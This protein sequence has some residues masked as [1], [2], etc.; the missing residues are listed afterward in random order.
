MNLTVI[1]II[2]VLLTFIYFFRHITTSS[3]SRGAA[4]ERRLEFILESLDAMGFEGHCLNNVFVPRKN[5][6]TTEIDVLF[7]TRK[8]LFVIESK[9]I[10]GY[11]FGHENRRN[12][13]STLYAGRRWYGN[14]VNKYHFFNPIWQNKSHINALKNYCGDITAFS[15]I[16]FGNNCELMDVSWDPDHV[17]VCHYSQFK[18][19]IRRIWDT[20]PDLYTDE[21]VEEIYQKL[22]A[23][24]KSEETV[25][26]HLDYAINGNNTGLCPAC[27]QSLVLRTARKGPNAGNQFYGCS[28]YPKCKYTQNIQIES[29]DVDEDDWY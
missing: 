9:N 2:V 3:S 17:T 6:S 4:G 8:G 5:G 28:N 16:A 22:A 1:I 29:G 25:E 13:T 21:E 20:A 27:G 26:K 14:K 19:E 12:W 18:K 11:I 24:D 23:L 10:S 15:I 7:I